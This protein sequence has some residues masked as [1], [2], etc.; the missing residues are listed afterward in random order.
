MYSGNSDIK[1]HLE[2]TKSDTK[3]MISGNKIAQTLGF[4]VQLSSKS[5][6]SKA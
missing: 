1:M 2:K 3:I 6:F 4:D 5:P